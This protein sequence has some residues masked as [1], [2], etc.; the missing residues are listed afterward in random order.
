[1]SSARDNSWPKAVGVIGLGIMGSALA[2]HL[3]DAGRDVIGFDIDP[4]RAHA[5]A[6]PTSGVRRQSPPWMKRRN[7]F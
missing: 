5:L 1:M 7:S 2:R 3:S 4:A 6:A